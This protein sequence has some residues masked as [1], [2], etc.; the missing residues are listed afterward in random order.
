M[1][2]AWLRHGRVSIPNQIYSLTTVTYN[3]APLFSDFTNARLAI[4]EMRRLHDMALVASLAWVVMPDHLHWLLA[5]GHSHSIDIVVKMMKGRTAAAINRRGNHSGPV[6]QRSYHDHAVRR[7]EYVVNVAR[8]IVA[9]PLRVGLVKRLGE[10]PHWD[11][12][13]L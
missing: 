13:W 7:E 4:G 8:Y 10:Y 12:V 9:N 2:Y 6:W 3:R 11:A 5:L 1:V